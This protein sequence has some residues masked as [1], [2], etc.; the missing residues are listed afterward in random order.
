MAIAPLLITNMSSI[1]RKP[2]SFIQLRRMLLSKTDASNRDATWWEQNR[3][4]SL[5]VKEKQIYEMVDSVK[6]VPAYKYYEKFGYLIGTGYWRS[7][8]FDIGPVY[9][10]ISFN[11]IEGVRL[12]VGGRTSINFSKKLMLEGHVAYGT[13]DETFKYALG[14]TIH[15]Q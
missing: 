4:D 9:K 14:M 11:S 12:R 7:G 8:R 1:S 10:F 2:T 3:P 15:A 6:K 13:K 5:E